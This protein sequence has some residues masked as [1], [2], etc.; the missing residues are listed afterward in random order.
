MLKTVND[1]K[2]YIKF[3]FNLTNYGFIS[4]SESCQ[5]AELYKN[6]DY[7]NSA[8]GEIHNDLNKKIIKDIEDIIKARL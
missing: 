7:F 3:L 2:I 1:Y 6:N 4:F 8:L 5:I